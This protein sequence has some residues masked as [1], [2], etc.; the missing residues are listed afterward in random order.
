MQCQILF[1]GKNKKNISKCRLLK[2]LPRVLSV[3]RITNSVNADETAH[4]EPSH[5]DLYC[6]QLSVPVYWVERIKVIL[7]IVNLKE[8]YTF[9]MMTCVW[10]R[11]LNLPTDG[12]MSSVNKKI[13]V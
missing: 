2:I 9:V 11:F 13:N 4:Y 5:P 6:L 1:S 8:K 7:L 12:S 10:T 3:N